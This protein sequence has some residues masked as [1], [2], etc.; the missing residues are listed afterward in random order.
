LDKVQI[1]RILEQVLTLVHKH[2]ILI[3]SSFTSLVVGI[4]VLEGVGR[5]L[6]PTMNI[7]K[8]SLPI[9]ARADER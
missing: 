3:D 2:H 4:V 6:D 7:F 8:E 1:G 5:Q 9:L